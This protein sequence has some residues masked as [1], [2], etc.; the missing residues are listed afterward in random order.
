MSRLCAEMVPRGLNTSRFLGHL[1]NNRT[2]LWLT[3]LFSVDYTRSIAREVA[4]HLV[5]HPGGNGRPGLPDVGW[6]KGRE[7]TRGRPGHNEPLESVGRVSLEERTDSWTIQGI[8]WLI[9]KLVT[10]PLQDETSASTVR[11]TPTSAGFTFTLNVYPEPF[12]Q[13]A[14]S[15]ASSLHKGGVGT[16]L[17]PDVGRA[18]IPL[19]RD[20]WCGTHVSPEI[21]FPLEQS[22]QVMHSGRGST[23]TLNALI[24]SGRGARRSFILP[25]AGQDTTNHRSRR[26][27]HSRVT[28]GENHPWP[29]W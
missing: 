28:Q 19:H 12:K 14:S 5:D 15:E 29:R 11:W 16:H 17:R 21:L 13:R 26:Q 18:T 10:M 8:S 9:C 25:N 22:G 3:P 1:S 27:A 20:P 4:A 6:H 2:V 7:D 23:F 24:G